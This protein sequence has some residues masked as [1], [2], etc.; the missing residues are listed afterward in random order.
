[1]AARGP[2]CLLLASCFV[3][4]LLTTVSV[5]AKFDVVDSFYKTNVERQAEESDSNQARTVVKPDAPA[6]STAVRSSSSSSSSSASAPSSPSSRGRVFGDRKI[7]PQGVVIDE[8]TSLRSES[9][10]VEETREPDSLHEPSVHESEPEQPVVVVTE[11][12]GSNEDESVTEQPAA[13]VVTGRPVEWSYP[14]QPARQQPVSRRRQAKAMSHRSY[15][16]STAHH[17]APPTSSYPA[18]A[19]SPSSSSSADEESS[20]EQEAQPSIP[21]PTKPESGVSVKAGQASAR[22]YFYNS[23]W[24]P[25]SYADT[26][27]ASRTQEFKGPSGYGQET[28]QFN[29]VA[30]KDNQMLLVFAHSSRS[31]LM[32]SFPL[33]QG[34]VLPC[35]FIASEIR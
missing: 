11:I 13:S 18:P 5:E 7:K 6:D 15:S 1:M 3:T 10:R 8:P 14:S 9:R 31:L 26:Q 27:Q 20:K 25:K 32:Q 17:R 23:R 35:A 29:K 33:S 21:E 4:V 19:P 34:R 24:V 28:Q 22:T 12:I 2:A 30:E 16:S